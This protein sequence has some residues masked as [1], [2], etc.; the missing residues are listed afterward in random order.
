[1]N[2]RKGTRPFFKLTLKL[3]AGR[4]KELFRER[5]RDIHPYLRGGNAFAYKWKTA[6]AQLALCLV[7]G[8]KNGRYQLLF[9]FVGV[10]ALWRGRCISANLLEMQKMFQKSV[11]KGVEPIKN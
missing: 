5:Y 3:A 11:G 1:M 10:R 6:R 4:L 2:S 7:A 9:V 8:R